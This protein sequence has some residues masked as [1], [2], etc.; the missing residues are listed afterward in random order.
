TTRGDEDLQDSDTEDYQRIRQRRRR[1]SHFQDRDQT[2]DRSHRR[3]TIDAEND[4]IVLRADGDNTYRDIIVTTVSNTEDFLASVQDRTEDW[5]N[6]ITNI[7]KT[8]VALKEQKQ[9]LEQQNE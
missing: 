1:S 4:N 2:P 9:T 8:I 3:Y 5:S 7:V 6:G